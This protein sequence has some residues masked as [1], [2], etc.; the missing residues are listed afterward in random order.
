MVIRCHCLIRLGKMDEALIFLCLWINHH[1]P[2]HVGIPE[3]TPKPLLNSQRWIWVQGQR[4]TPLEL[5]C[6][7]GD[8]MH[9]SVL[10]HPRP[11][12]RS[13]TYSDGTGLS[14]GKVW[15]DALCH[16]GQMFQWAMK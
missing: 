2:K 4:Q 16:V 12:N 15:D 5:A 9:S 10:I 8:C 1:D 13:W 11:K 14:P 7:D 6:H 3:L